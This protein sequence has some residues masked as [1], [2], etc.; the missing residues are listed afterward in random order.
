M[1]TFWVPEGEFTRNEHHSWET[2]SSLHGILLERVWLHV[3]I[4]AANWPISD[5][6]L[7]N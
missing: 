1:D 6:I 3:G 2:T 7:G 5:L 4:T